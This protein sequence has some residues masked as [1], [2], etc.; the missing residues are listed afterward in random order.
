MDVQTNFTAD[1]IIGN[2]RN[3]IQALASVVRSERPK[4]SPVGKCI[5]VRHP[6]LNGGICQRGN[7]AG[8]KLYICRTGIAVEVQLS[9]TS[10]RSR[11]RRINQ[12][13][14]GASDG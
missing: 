3:V 7:Q 1:R 14:I 9:I 6:R 4:L 2:E 12:S 13:S 5:I 11:C 10:E 8:R